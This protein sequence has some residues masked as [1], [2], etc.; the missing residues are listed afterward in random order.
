[1]ITQRGNI[2]FLILLA[3]VLFAALS[4]AVTQGMRGGGKD[5]GPEK[6]KTL[7]SQ[8][9]QNVSLMENTMMRAM[10]VNGV[11]GYG[12][13]LSGI[14]SSAAANATCTQSSCKL[15]A[16]QGGGVPDLVIPDWART[17]GAAN[18][19]PTFRMIRIKNI[20]TNGEELVA[21]Y[22]Y[23]N[24]SLC[25]AL[26]SVLGNTDIDLTNYNQGWGGYGNYSG[27]L[28]DFPALSAGQLGNVITALAGK[29]AFCFPHSAEGYTFV[30]VLLAQ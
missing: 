28:T 15:F 4:Y 25:E 17:S 23:L 8:I 18:S 30:N 13:D 6:F 21:T 12:F 5:A 9:L 14:A 24:L 26:N 1:M 19:Y 2:L 27:T 11:P 22:R 16:S 29:R 10:T 20:G 7:A 3:V